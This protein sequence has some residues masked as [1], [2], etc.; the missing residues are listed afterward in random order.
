MKPDETF[1]GCCPTGFGC[2]NLNG[3]TCIMRAKSTILP[4]VSCETGASNNFGFTTLPNEEVTNLSL[5]APMI[6]LAFQ[7]SDRTGLSTI[8]SSSNNQQR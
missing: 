6:Q 3:Q 5:Y 8:P 7:S 1:V 2:D 4:T